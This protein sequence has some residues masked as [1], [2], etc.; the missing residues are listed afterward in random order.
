MRVWPYL[1]HVHIAIRC[2][3]RFL[4]IFADF[5]R[6]WQNLAKL[7]NFLGLIFQAR[8]AIFHIWTLNLEKL[9]PGA[10]F[11]PRECFFSESLRFSHQFGLISF[12][13]RAIWAVFGRFFVSRST[14]CKIPPKHALL[15]FGKAF[16]PHP[17]MTTLQYSLLIGE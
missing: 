1:G 16:T 14:S 10:V 5:C 7:G 6:F 11:A 8:W 9:D 2:F 12:D 4:P 17:D 3:R 13:F 15:L